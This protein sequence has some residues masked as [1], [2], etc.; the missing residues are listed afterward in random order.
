MPHLHNGTLKAQQIRLYTKI[1]QFII[2]QARVGAL[3]KTEIRV[4]MEEWAL[5]KGNI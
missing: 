4:T 3:E 5:Q 2:R 1:Q